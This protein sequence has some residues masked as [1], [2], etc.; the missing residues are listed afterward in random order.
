MLNI[1]KTTAIKIPF[2]FSSLHFSSFLFF[3]SQWK[4]FSQKKKLSYIFQLEIFFN[5]TTFNFH[6]FNKVN[7]FVATQYTTAIF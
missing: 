1:K 2:H 5:K 4:R 3:S 6:S 7:D